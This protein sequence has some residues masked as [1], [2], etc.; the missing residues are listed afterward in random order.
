MLCYRGVHIQ[1]VHKPYRHHWMQSKITFFLAILQRTLELPSQS[2]K[3]MI[4]SISNQL[5]YSLA[6]P[7]VYNRKERR[8][9]YMYSVYWWANKVINL[10]DGR[11]YSRNKW[12]LLILMHNVCTWTHA[13]PSYIN[14]IMWYNTAWCQN[15]KHHVTNHMHIIITLYMYNLALT[16]HSTKASVYRWRSRRPRKKAREKGIQTL[17]A[18]ART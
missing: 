11:A 10:H 16:W 4:K 1:T 7:R 13:L 12:P 8:V 2:A 18:E 14:G 9:S 17:Q 15:S 3:G 6:I 5:H